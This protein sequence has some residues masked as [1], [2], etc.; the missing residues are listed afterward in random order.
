[1]LDKERLET[2]RFRRHFTKMELIK[3]DNI[4]SR[5]QKFRPCFL[6]AYKEGPDGD[7]INLSIEELVIRK[8]ELVN[9]IEEIDRQLKELE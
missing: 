9:G 8:K 6:E 1:M 5:K 3:V 4:I 7:L 2:L